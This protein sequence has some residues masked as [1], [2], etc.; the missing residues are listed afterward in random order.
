MKDTE[1]VESIWF[2]SEMAICE[3][4]GGGVTLCRTLGRNM[5]EFDGM[6]C[7]SDFYQ[8]APHLS[9]RSIKWMSFFRS[10][11]CRRMLGCRFSEWCFRQ[12]WAE[13]WFA[14]KCARRIHD[15]LPA[16]ST[17]PFF[18]ISPQTTLSIR[19]MEKLRR[20]IPLSYVTW[21]MDDNWVAKKPGNGEWCY[22][23]AVA[24]LLSRHLREAAK[25]VTISQQM[26]EL[27]RHLFG[28]DFE[29][30]FAPSPSDG[31]RAP[32]DFTPTRKLAYFGTLSIWPG[33]ALARL[34]PLLPEL[35]YTLDIF[36]Y[37]PLP[38]NLQHSHV[39]KMQPLPSAEVQCKMREYDAVLL[40]IGFTSATA[41]YTNFN[42]ATKMAECLGSGTV[43]LAIGPEHAAMIRYFKTHDLGL[44]VSDMSLSS[45]TQA[46][47]VIN[48]REL[49]SQRIENDLA[50]V[51]SWLTQA[52]ARRRWESIRDRVLFPVHS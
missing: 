33:D 30:L 16:D 49:R 26:G 34:V 50:H 5:D 7:L 6:F 22:S 24:P 37:H 48:S 3:Q 28:V 27:Y 1:R 43:T 18:L 17:R 40:P 12:P 45:V 31:I 13:N 21:I 39:C 14:R 15:L 32:T 20:L 9:D 38:S 42:I 10:S 52:Q 35:G 36:S 4:H 51:R 8:I 23:R 41:S 19:V 44:C 2:L 47:N 46:F 11:F 25:V 29:V